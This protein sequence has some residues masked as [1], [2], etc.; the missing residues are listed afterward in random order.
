MG[1]FV[2]L[3]KYSVLCGVV[4]LQ[5]V[6]CASPA[7]ETFNLEDRS[8]DSALTHW[9]SILSILFEDTVAGTTG[10]SDAER[11][12]RLREYIPINP[13]PTALDVAHIL[14]VAWPISC[15][16]WQILSVRRTKLQS[17][18][19]IV[20]SFM[21]TCTAEDPKYHTLIVNIH[22]DGYFLSAPSVFEDSSYVVRTSPF[23]GQIYLPRE[24]EFR[25]S[26]LDSAESYLDSA[27]TQFGGVGTALYTFVMRSQSDFDSLIGVL[28]SKV[29]GW[30]TALQGDLFLIN[31]INDRRQLARAAC[32]FLM[33]SSTLGDAI[34]LWRAQLY[35]GD[36]SSY[37]GMRS[38][39]IEKFEPGSSILYSESSIK[40]VA[41]LLDEIYRRRNWEGIREFV[42]LSEENV[43]PESSISR[44][45]EIDKTML[46]S[47]LQTAL[48]RAQS[49]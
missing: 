18:Y 27:T 2:S 20:T 5:F 24:Y 42:K 44:I 21:D 3:A 31:K 15:F 16:K 30:Y 47:L 34:G 37:R 22:S 26:E 19:R 23:L 36:Y 17:V 43:D 9:R 25:F 33:N 48:R 28:P 46:R 14:H 7:V 32:C 11:E 13:P 35:Y 29:T 8:R 49:K 6:S 38:A 12:E 40:L 4:F 45:L 39:D 10:L 41:L 1:L